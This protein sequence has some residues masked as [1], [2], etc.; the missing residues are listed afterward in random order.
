MHRREAENRSDPTSTADDRKPSPARFRLS[1]LG[2]LTLVRPD[3]TEDPSLVSSGRKLVLL[4]YLALSRRPI[5]RD[6]LATFLWGHR[7]DERARHSLRDALSVLRQSLGDMIPRGR[8]SVAL[9]TDAPL[10][11]D[12]LELRA[13]AHAGDHPSVVTLYRGPFLDGVH[14]SDASEVEDWISQERRSIE[15]LFVTSCAAECRRL[16]DAHDWDACD[17]VARRWLA[18]D[19]TDAAAFVSRLRAMSAPN[20]PAALRGAVAEYQR[21]VGLLAEEF[22]ETPPAAAQALSLELS[23]RLARAREPAMV[24]QGT[25]ATPTTEAPRAA[26]PMDSLTSSEVP[27][28]ARHAS[29]R[30]VAAAGAALL[31]LPV[32]LLALRSRR[33]ETAVEGTVMVAAI[34]SPSRDPNDAWLEAG[35]PRLLTSSLIRERVPGVVDPTRVR[36]VSRSAGLTN[37][38]GSI[39]EAAAII[40][41]KRLRAATLV[42]GEITRGGGRFLLHLAVRDVASGAVKH[43][44]ALSDTGLFALVDQATARLLAAVDRP[45]PGFRFEDVETSSVE[46]YRAYVLA[47]ERI[48]DG[49]AA[50][51]AQLLDVAVSADSTF[52][53]ALQKRIGL[54]GSRTT[55]ARDSVRRLTLALSRTR[56]PESDFDRRMLELTNANEQGDAVRAEQIARDL[57]TRYPRDARAYQQHI[58]SLLNL[59]TFSEAGHVATLALALD[60]A[61]RAT[62]TGSC[63]TCALYGVLVTTTLAVGDAPGAYAAGRRGVGLKPLEPAPWYALARALVSND[64]MLEAIDAAERAMRLAPRERSWAESFALLLLET[65][66]LDAADSIIEI[67]VAREMNTPWPVAT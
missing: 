14:I 17:A 18:A 62:E 32:I 51:A 15:R 19:P 48:D 31:L 63:A 5:A 1:M 8:E 37:S 49:R 2:G 3:G 29:R 40:V 28:K 26:A 67:G 36:A 27:L 34:E 20:T 58:I 52:V 43:R 39:D 10:D 42:S 22:D 24:E 9:S 59:G 11:V 13:A 61:T 55:S 7:D 50:D 41:A 60:S 56:R 45:G 33:H 6:R 44:I 47:L 4:S 46:A 25:R 53:A 57:V 16:A 38:L 64:S 30:T 54:L 35:L 66:H 23:D 65:G 21:H 12:V